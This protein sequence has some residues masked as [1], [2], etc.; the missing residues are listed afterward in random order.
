MVFIVCDS[1][2]MYGAQCRNY[3]AY[4]RSE[5]PSY[6]LSNCEFFADALQGTS[7]LRGSSTDASCYHQSCFLCAVSNGKRATGLRPDRM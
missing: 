6:F 2:M 5:S 4:W 1:E 7:N 3:D